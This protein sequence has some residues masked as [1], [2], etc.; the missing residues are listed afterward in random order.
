M[1][2][3][4]LAAVSA[5]VLSL[6]LPAAASART[7]EG[8]WTFDQA[9]LAR[10]NRALGTDIDHAWLD[11]VRLGAVR[12]AGCSASLVSEQGL[13]LTNQ[14]CIRSCVQAHAEPGQDLLSQG[15]FART[16]DEELACPGQVAEVL[17][18]IVDVTEQ[19][20]TAGTGMTGAEYAG[21]QSRAIGALEREA[22]GSDPALRCQVINFYRGGQYKLY[23][24]RRYSDVR[25]VYA[26]EHQAVIFGGDP[27]NFNFPRYALDAA[28]LRVYENGA[29]ASTPDHLTWNAERIVDGQPVFV[30]GNPGSTSRLKT[31]DQLRIERDWAIPAQLRSLAELRGR[32]IRFAEESPENA[33]MTRDALR[34]IENSLKRYTGMHQ[35]LADQ[36]FY[37]RLVDAETQ[38]RTASMS[39][40]GD[41]VDAW[42]EIESAHEHYVRLMPRYTWLESDAGSRSV[43]FSYA[44]SIVRAA[45]ERERP[46]GQRLAGFSDAAL[47][48]MG[49]SLA[50]ARNIDTP[51]ESLYLQ[52]WLSK[53]R[54]NLGTDDADVQQMLGR[55]SPE[56]LGARLIEGTTLADPTVRTAL[57]EG[58]RAAV[59][60]SD[61]PLIQFVLRTD[62]AAR[63]VRSDWRALVSAPIDRAGERIAA[64]RFARA[65][66]DDTYPDATFSLRLSYGRVAGW[67][68]GTRDVPSTTTVAGLWDRATGAA[69]FNLSPGLEAARDRLPEDAVYTVASTNDIVG[70]NSGSPLL[71]ARGEV[72][73][74]VFDGNLE[75]LGGAYGYDGSRNRAVTVTAEMITLALRE[76][77]D[78]GALADELEGGR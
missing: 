37:N 51:L 17:L 1:R 21:A 74:A 7:D 41:A 35:A 24:F 58:G 38:L 52:F 63:A 47:G 34:S 3:I 44:R 25:L 54:E 16:R 9:P 72:I 29:P 23:R 66:G 22:C 36:H 39:A 68:N 11:R 48:N 40:D 64:H 5:S 55:D 46:E 43:L 19:V 14:H 28:F 32:V 2:L 70:G 8:M 67:N 60:A 59:E 71:N 73:G 6:L 15:V 33:R 78:M 30:A 62:A 10:I 45:Y 57:F 56:A 69:P 76:I 20:Q 53:T 75:S 18:E 61:D 31:V 42:S 65:R 12:L 4:T 77:Y 27:D 13:V 50:Q 49:R 26:P